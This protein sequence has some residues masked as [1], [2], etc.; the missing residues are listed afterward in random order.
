MGYTP[1]RGRQGEEAASTSRSTSG[2]RKVKLKDIA[3]FS[4]QFATMINSGPADPARAVDPGRADRE[5]GA[6]RDAGRRC[7]STS[8]RARRCPARWRST[9]RCSTTC[10]S[11]MVKSGETGGCSTTSCCSWPTMIERR[12]TCGGKIKSAMTYPVA[13][14]ALVLLIMSRDAAVRRPAVRGHLRRSSAARCRCRHGSCS[15][16]LGRG[17]EVLVRVHRRQRS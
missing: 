1:A 12:S 11:S 10:T 9:R 5:Q 14:V 8:S 13:V 7:G 2:R 4:R 15:W 17:Q 6:R 16:R 3:V